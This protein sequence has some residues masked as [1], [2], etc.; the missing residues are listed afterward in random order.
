MTNCE[1]TIRFTLTNR[2]TFPITQST[3]LVGGKRPHDLGK[4]AGLKYN[5]K[6]MWRGAG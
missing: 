3:G 4:P 2:R 1:L 6:H 5:S